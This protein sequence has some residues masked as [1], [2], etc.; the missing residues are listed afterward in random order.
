MA[1]A[2]TAS[3]PAIR[4][5]WKR[6]LG[7]LLMVAGVGVLAWVLV[8]WQWNDPF[9][10]LYTRW[11]QRRLDRAYTA[12]VKE[13]A[14][15][16]VVPAGA[17]LAETHAA[18]RAAATRFHRTADAGA[19][20]GRIVVPRLDLD[21]VFV[22]GTD[23]ATLKKGPGLHPTTFMPGEGK[24]V[25]IAGHRTTY[26]APFAR[27]DRLERG[28]RITLEMPYGTFV[29]SVTGHRIVDDQDLSVL[30]SR[31]RE[32]V[33]LQ[34]CHPRFFATQRYIVWARP[35]EVRPRGG[36]PYRPPA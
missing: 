15:R 4:G 5:R 32:E 16:P 7:T 17:D 10:S 8:V 34:A 29:Y 24:L 28:D 26:L 22:N 25:Y 12:L 30:R 13:E 31:G 36:E 27:I 9:T 14:A 20:I 1:T 33:A 6:R 18:V 3:R 11:E 35:I 21:M 23:S 2:E 19:A